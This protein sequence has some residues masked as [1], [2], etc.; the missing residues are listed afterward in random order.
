MMKRVVLCLLVALCVFAL[1][2]CDTLT[3]FSAT[4]SP[5]PTEIPTA[6]PA[7][8]PTP[9]PTPTPEPTSRLPEPNPTAPD[10]TPIA[11]DPIDMPTPTPEPT[12]DL[13]YVTRSSSSNGVSFAVPSTWIL[14]PASVDSFVR[15]VE[16]I[17]E[18]HDGYQTKLTFEKYDRGLK[19]TSEDAKAYLEDV[20]NDMAATDGYREFTP[21]DSI[22]TLELGGVK[23]YYCYY[24]GFLDNDIKVRGRV[25][26]V[27]KD[28]ALYQLRIT[29][30]ANWFS[31]YNHVYRQARN[32]FKFF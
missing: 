9:S 14:D 3:S 20:L 4:P 31:Y 24:S 23:G 21:N 10:A 8:S 11:I 17:S 5:L 16:P 25:V 12:P 2:G 7:P 13:D 1:S 6:T 30:P 22:G 32:T 15:Y 19:Q 29:T 18:M 28:K 26:V 27:A